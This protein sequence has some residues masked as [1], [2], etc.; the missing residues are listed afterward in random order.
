[1]ILSGQ[2]CIAP[3]MISLPLFFRSVPGS[4]DPCEGKPVIGAFLSREAGHPGEQ[5]LDPVVRTRAAHQGADAV[6]A[7]FVAERAVA[8]DL[9]LGVAVQLAAAITE[10][11]PVAGLD[12]RTAG[13]GDDPAG[14]AALFEMEI[15]GPK[16]A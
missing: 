10:A 3:N 16:L 11:E 6:D 14:E 9:Y 4:G 15:E 1:M 5:V 13:F 2:C 8:D 7:E 12:L